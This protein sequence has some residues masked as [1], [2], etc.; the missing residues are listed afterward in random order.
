[1]VT[2]AGNFNG[3]NRQAAPLT[4]S[5]NGVWSIA[6][7]F[8][9]GEKYYYKFLVD[10]YPLADPDNPDTVPDGFGGRNS[11]FDMKRGK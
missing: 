2:I 6:L 9:A 10:G 8:K 11:V 3:W 7:P 4:E 1:V 5:T